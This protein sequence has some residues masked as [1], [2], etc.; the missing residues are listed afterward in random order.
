MFIRKDS[1]PIKFINGSSD[2]IN[3]WMM[4]VP[5]LVGVRWWVKYFKIR[6]GKNKLMVTARL[7]EG[8]VPD[9]NDRL[10]YE[11]SI[12]P[13]HKDGFSSVCLDSLIMNQYYAHG[14][15]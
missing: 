9:S 13:L 14:F 10:G 8:W 7:E 15:V 4:I 11:V 5:N 6:F 3:I 2:T 1:I 12:R